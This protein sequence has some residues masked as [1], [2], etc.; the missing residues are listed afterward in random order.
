MKISIHTRGFSLSDALAKHTDSKLRLALGL[1]RDKIQR[2][3]VF[4]CDVNGPKGGE[5][6]S[7]KIKVKAKGYSSI[8][9]QQTANDMY[10]AIN[11][12]SHKVKRTVGRRLDKLVTRRPVLH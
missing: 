8:V 1:Y 11:I 4:L 2:A 6:M 10:D 7:C 5:D 3:E 12:C 9:T